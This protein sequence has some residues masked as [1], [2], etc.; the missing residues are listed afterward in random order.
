MADAQA[1]H[2]ENGEIETL[3]VH[4][5]AIEIVGWACRGD[6][7]LES[8]SLGQAW[9][10]RASTRRVNVRRP[11]IQQRLP[12]NPTALRSGFIF[13][14]RL[15]RFFSPFIRVCITFEDGAIMRLPLPRL[16][17]RR[18]LGR[19]VKN[20]GHHYLDWARPVKWLLFPPAPAPIQ[21]TPALTPRLR[22][23][24]SRDLSAEVILPVRN[25]TGTLETL[26][27]KLCVDSAVTR[28]I[29]V[30]DDSD[31]TEVVNLLDKAVAQYDK[32]DLIRNSE[33][34]GF[35]ASVNLALKQV[36]ADCILLNSDVDVPEGWVT[37][38][39]SPIRTDT[40]VA[41]TTPFTNR[42]SIMGFPVQDVENA[43]FDDLPVDD[44]DAAFRR[45]R[46]PHSLPS[47]PTGVGF[48]MGL[49][50]RALRDTG[51]LDEDAFPIGY[52]EENDWCQR[53]IVNGYR[54]VP[55]PDLYVY[56][57][58]GASFGRE[59]RARLLEQHLSVLRASYPL[60][61]ESVERFIQSNELAAYRD[62]ATLFIL[63]RSCASG[64]VVTLDHDRGGGAN[65]FREEE[66]R[67]AMQAGK[68]SLLVTCRGES[69]GYQVDVK[70]ARH[71]YAFPVEDS[72]DFFDVLASLP[73]EDI[74]IN[75]LVFFR[76]AHEFLQR[77]CRFVAQRPA[78]N[79]QL[80]LH[81][82]HALCPS[83]TLIDNHG[84]FCDIPSEDVCMGCLPA[85][86][87]VVS[88]WA[89]DIGSWR[90]AWSTML[91]MTSTV[92]AFS[93]VSAEL[94]CRV[95]PALA[96]RVCVIPHRETPV[97]ETTAV[98][99]ADAP[100]VLGVV[101]NINL[102]KGQDVVTQL[103][104]AGRIPIV[105]LGKL[106]GRTGQN[107][108][109]TVHG[110]YRREE[111]PALINRYGITVGL[112]PS[113][114]PETYNFVADEIMALQMPLVCFDIGAHAKRIGQYARGRVVPLDLKDDPERLAR[115]IAT[116]YEE[117]K[118]SS[119]S[120]DPLPPSKRPYETKG[121]PR[122][123]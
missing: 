88:P 111:L 47:M 89:G 64:V 118:P 9:D 48:C 98:S 31:D 112:V 19:L 13:Q 103:A 7:S 70:H 24:F 113:I 66:A 85:N 95:Y 91:K 71:A 94:F 96:D 60:Y 77:L 116:L 73:V 23:F 30:D 75:S 83:H 32:V 50:W 69:G 102:A 35:T 34:R 81:D 43:V 57:E 92:R 51:F 119:R 29:L 10:R 52:G 78:L 14:S 61:E 28:L 120:S 15:P 21:P 109:L 114:W 12:G 42:G 122:G 1:I 105:V 11:D 108:S 53:A 54:H 80:L 8:V 49:S 6:L 121:R 25:G 79:T 117:H 67:D 101:G 115:E 59:E 68:L 84:K 46:V 72:E 123:L 107:G 18:L 45:L 40:S 16:T 2:T 104:A 5:R 26:L 106:N 20:L 33:R 22:E 27:H 100:L 17:H 56:H 63:A 76:G 110:P 41:S 62:I 74:H 37:R 58:G 4:R 3:R 38:L 82:Y 39:L 99:H 93:E 55:V 36:R 44:M 65:T 97:P 90:A 86:R 87:H